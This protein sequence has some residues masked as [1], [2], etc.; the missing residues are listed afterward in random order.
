MCPRSDTVWALS[1]RMGVGELQ[2]RLLDFFR[3]YDADGSG[4]LEMA[5]F[6]Q[7]AC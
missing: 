6:E 7:G 4:Y 2:D 1:C 5:E 3:S